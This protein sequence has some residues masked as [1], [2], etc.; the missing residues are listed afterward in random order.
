MS[1]KYITAFAPAS[2]GNIA[3]G[4]DMLGLAITGVGDRV[5]ARRV[6]EEG[7]IIKEIYDLNNQPH[8]NLSKDP[9]QNTASIAASALWRAKS[10]VGGIELIIHKG[11][12][13]QSGM[14]SSAASA[15]AGALAAN[16]LLE[17]P[18]TLPE[19]LPAALEGEEFASGG[20][21]AD[22]VAPS[23]IGGMVF[24]P[25][26][27]LPDMVSID[28]PK[29]ISSVLIHPDLVVNTAESRGSLLK[30]Y[31]MSQ[32][33]E[34]QSYLAGFLIGLQK[35]DLALIRENLRDVIIEP[36]RSNSVAYFDDVKNAAITAGALGCSLSGSGPSIFALCEDRFAETI[37]IA[38]ME[39][40]TKNKINSQGW[41]SS[42]NANGAYLE[43]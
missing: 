43:N 19:L 38:M 13:L 18:L 5:S 4:F 9:S 12:P 25:S 20:I 22:N 17:K 24:C 10:Q 30:S 28:T 41:V 8:N 40:F 6:T 2:I 34:Q 11:I 16:G 33:L 27:S 23:L 32:W 7:V 15:V 21:H 39:I 3:V 42:L 36:Q 26:T 1:E 37:K 29:N 31:L 35:N 14:G